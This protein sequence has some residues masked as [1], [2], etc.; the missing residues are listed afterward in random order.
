VFKVPFIEFHTGPEPFV[1]LFN[2]LI[3]DWLLHPRAGAWFT[4]GL[5]CSA[6]SSM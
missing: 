2:G 3:D 4:S 5:G 1:P 6:A